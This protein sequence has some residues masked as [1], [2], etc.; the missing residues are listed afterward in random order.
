MFLF[1][2]NIVTTLNPSFPL[3]NIYALSLGAKIETVNYENKTH[4]PV[5]DIISSLNKKTSSYLFQI[6]VVHLVV[7]TV[8]MRSMNY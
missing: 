3:Y 7:Y 6:H 5:T 2:N 4:I 8:M 1:E